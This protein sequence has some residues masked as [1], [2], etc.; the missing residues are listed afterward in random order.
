MVYSDRVPAAIANLWNLET[1]IILER[2]K[3]PQ[4]IWRMPQFRHVVYYGRLPYPRG[5]GATSTLEN[6]H[7]LSSLPSFMCTERIMEMIPNVRKLKILC[8]EYGA[9]LDNLAY[10]PH[11]ENLE[12][13]APSS[14]QL[15]PSDGDEFSLPKKLKK[16][17][18]SHLRLPWKEMTMVG[19]SPNLQVL[20]LRHSACHGKTWETTEGG[21]PQL[22]FLLIEES[23]LEQIVTRSG[24][25][26]TLRSLVLH[27]C[28][29]LIEIPDD[30]GEIPTLELIEVTGCWKRSVVELAIR[31]QEELH[32]YGNDVHVC[33]SSLPEQSHWV[34]RICF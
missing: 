21:F 20:K 11:L 10:L 6:L 23:N 32:S 8:Y 7:T 25:F 18:L 28:G 3:E 12:L 19:S 15:L 2:R 30:I 27:N 34:Q 1:L 31:I 29:Q 4:E 17:T 14:C 16:L 24:H 26:P 9:Y 22:E 33:C 5:R 13:S